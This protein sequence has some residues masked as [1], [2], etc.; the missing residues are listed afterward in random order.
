M[1]ATADVD[2]GNAAYEGLC[3]LT[4][5]G[6][7]RRHGQQLTGLGQALGLGRRGQQALVADALEAG[8][9]YIGM[10]AVGLAASCCASVTKRRVSRLSPKSTVSNSS[11]AQL[12]AQFH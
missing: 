8:G 12:I 6:V 7:G 9:Q 2:G 1:R 4:H 10:L 3:I 11:S 5:L